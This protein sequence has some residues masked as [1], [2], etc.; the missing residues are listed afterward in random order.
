MALL[1]IN[2]PKHLYCYVRAEFL[3]NLESHHGEFV[4]CVVFGASSQKNRALSFHVLLKTGAQFARLPLHALVS[5]PKAPMM[6]LNDLVLWDCFGD[7]AT[8]TEF[9]YLKEMEVEVKLKSGSYK[10]LYIASFDWLNNGFSETPEQ[11]KIM[12]LIALEN[13]CYALQPNN[14]L[15]WK[16]LS[17]TSSSGKLDYKTNTHKWFAEEDFSIALEDWFY[18]EVVKEEC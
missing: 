10:G 17:F 6:N 2:L 12:H 9:S 7:E 14:R 3:Y 8:V 16:E 5:S 13:G 11:H 4:E 15:K 1:N 18:Y